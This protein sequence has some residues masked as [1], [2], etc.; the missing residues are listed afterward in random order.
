MS[1]GQLT[2]HHDYESGTTVEGTTR[3]SPAHLAL[4]AH[5]SWTWSRYATAWL[6]RSSRHRQSKPY[7]IDEIERVLTDAGYTVDRD[8]DDTI[9]SVEEQESD[10]A[11]RMDARADR[12]TER[13][14]KQ[15]TPPGRRRTPCSTTFQ[16]G[17]R[18]WSVTTVM[19]LTGTGVSAPGTTST[20]PS[21][22]ASTPTSW[23]AGRKPLRITW[24]PATTR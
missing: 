23:P 15:R 3:N 5:P 6:L 19:R 7:A 9:P 21:R 18:C 4:K 13:A 14:G 2:I 17:S 12:L 8:I 11:G 1:L 10:R 24:V 16:W 20:S 22:K